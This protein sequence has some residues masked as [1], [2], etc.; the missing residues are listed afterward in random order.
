M[1]DGDEDDQEYD[2]IPWGYIVASVIIDGL[3]QIAVTAVTT[4]VF[5]HYNLPIP[6]A[7]LWWMGMVIFYSSLNYWHPVTAG[8]ILIAHCACVLLPLIAIGIEFLQKW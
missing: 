5:T 2:G 3:I 8:R 1:E 7:I 4:F 6:N